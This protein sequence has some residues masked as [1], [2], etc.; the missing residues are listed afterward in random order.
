M[1]TLSIIDCAISSPSNDC[2]NEIIKRT[3][4]P[5]TYHLPAMSGTETFKEDPDA[6]AYLIMRLG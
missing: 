2:L 6:K 3:K 4:V 1:E 5:Y